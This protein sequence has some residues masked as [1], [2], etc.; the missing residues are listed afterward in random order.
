MNTRRA[1]FSEATVGQGVVWE[2]EF[3]RGRAN[4]F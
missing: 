2:G 1:V 4:V 3:W